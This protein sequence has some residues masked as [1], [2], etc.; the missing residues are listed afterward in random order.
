MIEGG[1]LGVFAPEEVGPLDV[2]VANGVVDVRR[3]RRG[4]GRRR[5]PAVRRLLRRRD[6]AGGRCRRQEALRDVVPREPA[7]GL[8]RA[9]RH[10]RPRRRRFGARAA[11]RLRPRHGHGAGADRGE[12]RSA[13]SPTTRRTSPAPIDA[14][15]ADKAAR[16]LQLCDAHDLPV[17]FLCDTPGIMVGPGG[18]EDRPRCAT[19]A[20]LFVTGASLDGAVRHD[21]AAQGLRPRRPGDG[22]RQLQGAAVL[23]RLA[24]GRVRRHGARGRGAP[25]LPQG[26]RGHRRPRGPGGARSRRWST[27]CTSTA[28]R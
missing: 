24:D 19:P 20:R 25:R 6:R 17:L 15:G 12:A 10:R 11:G 22:G 8:R 18:G 13:S 14:D 21:R 27:A 9:G 7:A 4:R 26:A 16:F 2:Q 5:R 28:R 3:G 1:G 23:R